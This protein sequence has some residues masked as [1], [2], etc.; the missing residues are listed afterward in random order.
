MILIKEMPNSELER[1][2]KRLYSME[3]Q[4]SYAWSRVFAEVEENLERDTGLWEKTQKME[5]ELDNIGIPTHFKNEFMEMSE[6]LK[7]KIECPI[8]Y[9]NLDKDSVKITNCGHKYCK[10]CYNKLS[11]TTNECALCRKILIWKKNT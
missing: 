2:T 4:K 3:K 6:A 5:E 7:K 11:A 10:D 9:E 1:T 8:C